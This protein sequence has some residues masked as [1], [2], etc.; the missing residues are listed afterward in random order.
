V[1]EVGSTE[2]KAVDP[3]EL[4][5]LWENA[6]LEHD[7]AGHLL[8]A[9]GRRFDRPVALHLLRGW[10]ALAIIQARRSG[11]ADPGFESFEIDRESELLAPV[12]AKKRWLW[13][14]SFT[15]IR[16][17]ALA[18]A[19]RDE[20]HEVDRNSLTLQFRLLGLC[21]AGHH[22]EVMGSG[23]SWKRLFRARLLLTAAAAVVLI[24]VAVG[25]ANRL[26]EDDAEALYLD[27]EEVAE[28]VTVT[29]NIDQLREFKPRGY[30]W[31]ADGNVVFEDRLIVTLGDTKYPEV[32]SVA[33]D[34]N[35]RY[36]MALMRGEQQIEV[37]SVGPSASHGL[38]VY[39]VTVPGEASVEGFDSIVIQVIEGDGCHSIG[40]LMFEEPRI[41]PTR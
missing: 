39:T 27:F 3:G 28:P 29:V 11:F 10:H 19:W 30:P 41:W 15:A 7:A 33:L 14:D 5:E 31:D 20:P 23:R 8:L 26:D 22:G 40:H 17:A 13:E 18:E 35:D 9:D 6:R 16:E 25:L 36:S 12:A 32:I 4:L 24:L 34:G 2:A 37:L 1:I 38:E 21:I